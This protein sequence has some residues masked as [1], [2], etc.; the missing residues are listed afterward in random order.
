MPVHGILSTVITDIVVFS[1]N[2][3]LEGQLGPNSMDSYENGTSQHYGGDQTP[4]PQSKI[5]VF[6]ASLNMV[7]SLEGGEAI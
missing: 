7:S 6:F 4:P 2:L 3:R 5:R 1:R